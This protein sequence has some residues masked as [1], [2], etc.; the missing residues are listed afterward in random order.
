MSSSEHRTIKERSTMRA[1]LWLASLALLTLGACATDDAEKGAA[2]PL[3]PSERFAIEVRP[4][5][6]E[7][8]LAP[9]AGGLSQAQADALNDFVA[10]WAQGERGAI[11]IKAPEHGADPAGAYRTATD[12]RDFLMARGVASVQVRI[13]GYD[14]GDDG[15][16]PI[17]VGFM[18]Y[19]AKGPQCGQ[20]W[21][22]LTKVSDNREYAEFGCS[23]T[24]NV[25]AQLADPGDLLKP[26]Q[27]DAPDAERREGVLNKWRQGTTTSTPKDAQATGTF[28]QVGQ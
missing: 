24:A 18:R 2:A 22:S 7:L 3:T 20:S 16:A 26:R 27:M 23:V 13:V 15:H 5:P 9:H 12:T 21:D 6:Q 4:A 25:A 1:R 17:L 14:A 10:D 11:T 28:S 8:K 19:A